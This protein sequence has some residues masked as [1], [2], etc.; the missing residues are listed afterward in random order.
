MIIKKV[1]PARKFCLHKICITAQVVLSV[2]NCY[3]SMV[4][5][6]VEYASSVWDPHTTININKIEAIQ[7]RA[8][9]FC[10]NDFSRHSS[11]SNMLTTL[12]LPT[13]QQRR[14]RAKVLRP[15][16]LNEAFCMYGVSRPYFLTAASGRLRQS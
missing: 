16:F 11:V 12:D 10:L 2:A 6:I 15:G 8:A 5:P 1:L 13:L 7:K 3:K 4:R 14:V 9:R